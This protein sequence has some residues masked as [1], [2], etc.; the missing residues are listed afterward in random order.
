[1]LV[2]LGEKG[3]EPDV[4]AGL[5][6]THRLTEAKEKDLA[7]Q[8]MR[9]PDVLDAA[10]DQREPHQLTTFL[11]DLAAD[12]HGYYNA[13][14]IITDDAEQRNARL[15]LCVAVRHVL[16]NGLELLGVAAPESM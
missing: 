8:L 13:Y 1:M 12:F 4:A 7:V 14:R 16:A 15:A 9:Y 2:Q 10:V 6:A 5:A 11:R 3:L